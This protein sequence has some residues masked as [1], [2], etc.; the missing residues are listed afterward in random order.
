MNRSKL[1]TYAPKARRDFI[2][3]MTDR[4]AIYG[5]TESTFEPVTEEGDIAVI[6]GKAHPFSVA[7]KRRLLDE[8]VKRLGFHQVMEACAYTWFNRFAAI[9]FMELHGYLDHGYRVLSGA[10]PTTEDK[11]TTDNTEDTDR[12]G[13][14]SS[15]VKSVSSV[16]TLPEILLHAEHV[17]F[18]GL[19]KNKVIELKLDGTRE[20]ELYR[21]LLIA[22]CNALHS[23]MPFLF[24]KIDDETELLLPDNLLHSD[25]L[26]RQLVN[27]I[28]E[29]DWQPVEIIGWIYQFYISEKKDE[30]IGKVVKSEDIPAATQLFT[31]NW[32]V[33]Y[34][35]QNSLGRLWL[36]HHPDSPLKAKMEYYIEPAEQ[37]PEVQEQLKEIVRQRVL[38]TDN[39][40]NTDA[41]DKEA[42]QSTTISSLSVPSV[43]SVVNSSLNPE[44]LTLMD[45]AC[46]S[47]HILVEGYDIFKAIYLERGYRAKDIPRLILEKNLFGLEI[48]DRAAQLAAFALMMKARADDRRIFDSEAKPN[49]L[50]FQDSKGL[51][52][53]EITHALNSPIL[54]EELPPSEYLFEEIEDEKTPLFSEKTLAEKGFVSKGDIVSLLELFKDAKTFGSL[55]QVPPK[56][57]AKLPE[58]QQRLDDV[59]KL[60]DLTHASANVIRPLLRQARLLAGQYDAV[61]ANP[62]YMGGKHYSPLLKTFINQVYSDEKADLCVAFIERCL[63][64]TKLT[65]LMGQVTM[66]SWM[67]LSS[68]EGFRKRLLELRTITTM[69]HL[70]P[71]AF[72]QIGGHVVQV[73]AFTISPSTFPTYRGSYKRLVEGQ[74]EEKMAAF[75]DAQCFVSSNAEF[76]LIPGCAVAYWANTKAIQAFPLFPAMSE[77]ATPR[78]GMITS[79]N[80][81]F[82]RL[83]HEVPIQCFGKSCQTR[84]QAR[85]SGMKWF[86]YQK[87]GTFRKWYGNNEHVVNWHNDGYDIRNK[88]DETGRIP[89]HAF[90]EEYIFKPNVNWSAV[91]VS[92]FSVRI[93]EW[94]SLFDAGGSAAFPDSKDVKYLA[95]FLNSPISQYLISILNPTVNFQAWDIAKLPV[96]NDNLELHRDVTAVVEEATHLAHRDWDCL[97][98]SWD[99]Q[100]HPA[101]QHTAPMIHQSQDAADATCLARF[102][103]MKELEEENNRLFI[104]AYD[105]QGELSPEVLDDQITLYRPD[106]AEDIKRLLSYSIGCMMG[107]Y[108]LDRPGLIYAHGGNKDFEKI[109]FTTDNTESTDKKEQAKT[110]SSVPSVKSVVKFPPDDDGIIPLTDTAWFDDDATNRVIEFINVAWPGFSTTDSTDSTDKIVPIKS[111]SSLSVP[112]VLSVVKSSPHLEENVKFIAES[113]GPTKGEQP[114]DTIRRYLSHDFF[115]HHL[116]TYKRRPIYW[117]FSSGKQRAFQC[118]VYLHRYNEGILSRMR[119]EYVIPL[120][121]K[122]SARIEQL[123]GDIAAATST[124]FRSKLTKER[125]KLIKQQGELQ[126]FDEKLRHYADLRINLDLDDGVK[127]NYGKFGD[128]LAEVKAVCGEKDEE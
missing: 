117:L 31:P 122:T 120:Q 73:T 80:A 71:H 37:T 116:K 67:F 98:T 25:S 14:S 35:V 44:R 38:T 118:L 119:T 72:P 115:K 123:A 6:A 56:L 42:K 94:G 16:V 69:A 81:L 3:A 87:G 105:L 125:D 100:V 10:K 61:V 65:G 88:K 77:M 29:A 28:D 20:A 74:S 21:M 11:S 64:Y 108:S 2:R 23:A 70:G 63:N 85:L 86:P 58:I 55:I 9:R 7:A 8:R 91:T 109:Y 13:Y 97:E 95:G 101:R 107:R 62:P 99:F 75:V 127:V 43:L 102:T 60:G 59:L 41:I 114:R 24:E 45:P 103:R 22:Q 83:W 54:K 36:E 57:A 52:A 66:Q 104:E 39:T 30:V 121:G 113:L 48:D 84:E 40:D 18:P 79:N 47:G 82:V 93:T 46:G 27:E 128:L 53:A 126:T 51:N 78:A 15:S 124:A 49:I 26:I 106:R 12:K 76:Q 92:R 19:D 34:L 4:A 96:A 111:D 110:S 89:A 33:K 68:I 90:N 50:A 112:S 17:D 1:K 5:L 32:I